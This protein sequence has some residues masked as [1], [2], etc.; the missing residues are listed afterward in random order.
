MTSRR[1]P[2][3]RRSFSQFNPS[4]PAVVGVGCSLFASSNAP[5]EGF[6]NPPPGAF[7]L[8]RAGSR[9]AQVE[10]ASAITHNPANLTDLTSLDAALSI[11]AVRVSFEYEGS[12]GLTANTVDPWKF[13]PAMY[14][15]TPLKDNRFVVGLGLHSPYGLSNEW[16]KNGTFSDPT[17]W[18]YQTPW[19]TELKTIN[20]NPTVAY[21]ICD[22]LSVGV[23]LDVMWSEL[24][25]KQ[26]YPWG[27]TLA[28]GE[29]RARGSGV[30]VGGNIGI[31]WK[32]AERHRIA[33]AYRSQMKVDYDGN[34]EIGNI[35]AGNSTAP[36]SD[37]GSSITF[38]DIVTLGYGY[39]VNDRLRL[40]ADI[41]WLQFS[42]FKT[43]PFN[44]GSPPPGFSTNN[45]I[46]QD[47][48]D[49][50]TFGIGGDYQIN[51]QFTVRGSYQHYMN[52]VPD[53]TFSPTIPD[54]D[55]NVVTASLEYVWGKSKL[56]L[57][58]G[59]VLYDDR[60]ISNNQNPAF[61]GHYELSVHLITAGY[62]YSF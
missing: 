37:F 49:T 51:D 22:Q 53:E 2:K 57:A 17:S 36:E 6:R 38:P 7:G 60:N 48:K 42:N 39:Q 30:G 24:R 26:Y 29:M 59:L 16:D 45:S 9:A 10:D 33:L 32:V 3:F 21:K 35:P 27:P 4:L 1:Q 43:L 12:G 40:G 25:F 28:D 11:Q 13:L 34:F 56:E 54:S 46:K 8:G 41:E 20:F 19:F 61:N 47:W 31:T 23:G 50:F 52:P 58:Y 62:R 18:R 55:Q 15:A 5:A 44:I 14:A